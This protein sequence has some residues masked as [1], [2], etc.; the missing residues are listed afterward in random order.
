MPVTV[1]INQGALARFLH[2][3]GGLARRSLERRTEAVADEARRTAPGSMSEAITTR[4]D[5][6]SRG[7]TGHVVLTHR[8]A[9]YVTKG[10]PRHFIRPRRAKALRFQARSGDLVFAKLVDH[11]GN[12][13]NPFMQEALRAAR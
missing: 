11:P 5:E 1:T 9:V 13:P 12:K 7:L 3:R 2:A 8:A 10:T 6:T 4:Y